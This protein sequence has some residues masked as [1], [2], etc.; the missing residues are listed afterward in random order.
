MGGLRL[1]GRLNQRAKSFLSMRCQLGQIHLCGT[2][3]NIVAYREEP[4]QG[5]RINKRY[6]IQIYEPKLAAMGHDGPAR[7]ASRKTTVAKMVEDPSY[8]NYENND[9]PTS[10]RYSEVSTFVK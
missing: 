10:K 5:R 4:I 3:T 6:Y 9:Y 8:G 7:G 1:E 2:K